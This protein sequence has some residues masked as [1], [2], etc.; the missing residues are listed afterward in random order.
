MGNFN[1]LSNVKIKSNNSPLSLSAFTIFYNKLAFNR[2]AATEIIMRYTLRLLTAQQFERACALIMSCEKLRKDNAGL[3]GNDEISIGVYVGESLT[4]NKNDKAIKCIEDLNE[5]GYSQ[6]YKFLL[7]K[8]PNCGKELGP[9]Y[10]NKINRSKGI[11]IDNEW[12]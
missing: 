9:I 10:S 12:V 8:C 7:L 3:L 5:S 4:P 11:Y 2:P 1:W 6:Y